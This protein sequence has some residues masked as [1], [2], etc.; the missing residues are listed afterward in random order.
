MSP[1]NQKQVNLSGEI[2]TSDLSIGYDGQVIMSK[3][4]FTIR[5]GEVFFIMGGSGSGKS[6]LLKTLVGLITPISGGI[7]YGKTDFIAS[8]ERERAHILRQTGI[9]YQG[10]ALFSSM[11]LL[12]NVALPLRIHT[13]LSEEQIS[14]RAREKLTLVEL[15]AAAL[16][17]PHEISGGM[18][19]RAGLARALALDPKILFFDEPSAGLDPVT[20]SN[21][22]ATI[23][24]INK[25]LGTTVVIV[26]HELA[27]IFAIADRAVFL[28]AQT[29]RQL[30]VGKPT[31]MIRQS[32]HPYVRQ[33]LERK[34]SNVNPV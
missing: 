34:A 33:F 9:L 15:E 25:K 32:S 30:E 26:S 5:E 7:H 13:K 3:I 19:K 24:D 2:K 8:D 31:E 12:E 22:D 29:K 17:F 20:S 16:K 10:G 21:L 18:I 6:T 14:E 11:N 1:I 23:L 4:D 27:S 28:D